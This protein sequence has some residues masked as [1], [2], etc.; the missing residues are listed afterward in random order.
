MFSSHLWMSSVCP[1]KLPSSMCKTAQMGSQGKSW[2]QPGTFTKACISSSS[3]PEPIDRII[4]PA[5]PHPVWILLWDSE[6]I[7]KQPANILPM[8]I[9]IRAWGQK[10]QECA[11]LRGIEYRAWPISPYNRID[12]CKG[13]VRQGRHRD[14]PTIYSRPCTCVRESRRFSRFVT[15]EYITKN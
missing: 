8:E 3:D 10:G 14:P 6:S 7:K 4:I 12:Q 2:D 13:A 9:L 5:N 1:H 15:C 11:L